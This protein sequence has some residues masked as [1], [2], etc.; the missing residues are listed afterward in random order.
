MVESGATPLVMSVSFSTTLG[1]LATLEWLSRERRALAGLSLPI[2][3]TFEAVLALELAKPNA[4]MA[5]GLYTLSTLLS[6]KEAS[7]LA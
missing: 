7:T 1:Y 4:Q 5:E 6:A 3:A 2:S